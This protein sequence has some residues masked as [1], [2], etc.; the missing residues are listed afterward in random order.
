MLLLTGVLLELL[1][2]N[3]FMCIVELWDRFAHLPNFHGF[4]PIHLDLFLSPSLLAPFC[5]PLNLSSS[6]PLHTL[7]LSALSSDR[8]LQ[9]HFRRRPHSHSGL[10]SVWNCCCYIK[11]SCHCV[12]NFYRRSSPF[13]C[14]ISA[15]DTFIHSQ[16]CQV[17]AFLTSRSLWQS[18]VP[19]QTM[20]APN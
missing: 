2:F 19:S 9:C 10:S 1:T 7:L 17:R 11:T 13:H 12:W 5:P 6:S 20:R 4:H 16:D 15:L 3:G 8:M 18:V 14:K